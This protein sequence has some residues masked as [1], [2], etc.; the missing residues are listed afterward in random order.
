MLIAA[1]HDSP[2]SVGAFLDGLARG[3]LDAVFRPI[4][5]L[6]TGALVGW[7]ATPRWD[8][9][10]LGSVRADGFMPLAIEAGV[11]AQVDA[12]VLDHVLAALAAVDV[13]HRGTRPTMSLRLD[14]TTV[15]SE[16]VEADIAGRLAQHG[17]APH[18]LYLEVCGPVASTDQE[19]LGRRLQAIRD[20]GVRITLCD[21]ACT[22]T[23]FARLRSL[24]FDRLHLGAC[25]TAAIDQPREQAIVRAVLALA[26]DLSVDVVAD[27]VDTEAQD[28]V[29]RRLGCSLGHGARFGESAPF[30]QQPRQVPIASGT[31]SDLRRERRG[32]PVPANEVQRLGMVYDSGM[33]DSAPEGFFDALAAEAAT[34]CATPIALV[35]LVDVDRVFLKA[36]HGLGEAR[37][38]SRSASFCAHAICDPAPTVV[39][40]ALADPR[41]CD[42]PL[43]VDVPGLRSYAGAPLVS[44]DGI[45]LGTVCV[46]DHVA[47]TLT[48][49][50]VAALVRLSAHAASQVE[51]RARLRQ[52]ERAR[53]SHEAAERS[54]DELRQ[55]RRGPGAGF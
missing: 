4:V 9:P 30:P 7:Q 6:A 44:T 20:V 28:R 54:L 48:G 17:I 37:N 52:L 11:V 34:I 1:H 36:A 18:R 47:R 5:H 25:C 45:T 55:T 46:I 40:D 2:L 15:L 51:L 14:T 53:Q 24:P 50:Q 31:Q 29:L 10:R 43:V 49:E 16:G 3:Q 39:P 35:T 32:F 23:S 26:R 22:D 19:L 42:N 12:A 38:V 27:G 33:L 21:V 8:H 41:F 13:A